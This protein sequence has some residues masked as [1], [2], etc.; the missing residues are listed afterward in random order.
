MSKIG[1]TLNKIAEDMDLGTLPTGKIVLI[2]SPDQDTSSWTKE[3]HS[4]AAELHTKAKAS[5]SGKKKD[6]HQKAI[7]YHTSKANEFK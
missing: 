6:K 7:E 2:D 4:Q 3:D 5:S 1:K